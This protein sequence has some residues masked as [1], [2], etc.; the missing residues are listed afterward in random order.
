MS[1]SGIAES[2]SFH[3]HR[4][5]RPPVISGHLESANQLVTSVSE[6]DRNDRSTDRTAEVP[7][8]AQ[9][10]IGTSRRQQCASKSRSLNRKKHL[11]VGLLPSIVLV[12]FGAISANMDKWRYGATV[13]GDNGWGR[14]LVVF[15]GVARRLFAPSIF[16]RS[17]GRCDVLISSAQCP[18]FFLRSTWQNYRVKT[19]NEHWNDYGLSSGGTVYATNVTLNYEHIYFN[20]NA[21]LLLST[22]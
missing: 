19:I 1:R 7:R 11:T 9:E 8:R 2:Q 6:D 16:D 3:S 10:P 17:R 13:R 12:W 14:W 20:L 15:C 5:L 18:G 22:N 4:C 21:F